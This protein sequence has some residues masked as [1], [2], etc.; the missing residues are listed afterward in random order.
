MSNLL[1]VL[2]IGG[3]SLEAEQVAAQVI[4]NNISNAQTPGYH[5]Q[6]THYTSMQ[7]LGG[8]RD[9][10]VNRSANQL[11]EA[12][13]N[14]QRSQSRY[15]QSRAD[16]LSQV[17]S[18]VGNFDDVGINASLTELFNSWRQLTAQPQDIS[19]RA[20]VLARGQM[21]AERVSDAALHLSASQKLADDSILNSL[22]TVNDN[23]SQVANLNGLIQA[24]QTSGV[25]PAALMDQRDSLVGSLATLAGTTSVQQSNGDI[26]VFLGGVGVVSGNQAY[27]LVAERDVTSG[28]HHLQ[29]ANTTQGN[30][31]SR[32]RGGE[33]GAQFTLRDSDIAGAKSQ[34]DEFTVDVATAFN[35]VHSLGFGLDGLT[36][37]NFFETPI[38]VVGAASLLTLD[39]AVSNTP[40][41]L[42]AASSATTSAGGNDQALAIT[43]LESAM[44][45]RSNAQ[46]LGSSLTQLI[47]YSGRSLADAQA[48]GEQS[49]AFLQQTQTM[50]E[51]QHGVSLD[52]Q[53]LHL[54]RIQN[55]Y[56]AA[57]KLITTVNNMLD[58][59]QRL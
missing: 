16:G 15:A 29:V 9:V 18:A 13:L 12:Q 35:S 56:Q 8:V 6:D 11:L 31:D 27:L 49:H 48:Q 25:V 10:Q 32:I 33:L 36:G 41:A 23:F 46:T 38:T 50:W 43:G 7:G 52:E 3:N 55:A 37:R 53:M 17:V 30:M 54:S 14:T 34:L 19:V 22:S 28:F 5:R 58:V 42:A 39:A 4:G 20:E 24:A 44:V 45:A 1:D 57:A 21:F 51:Q 26:S 47:S 2:R 59:L 40:A